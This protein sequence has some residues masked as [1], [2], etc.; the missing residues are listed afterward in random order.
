MSDYVKA[1]KGAENQKRC[2][3]RGTRIPCSA[4]QVLVY[5]MCETGNRAEFK[6]ETMLQPAQVL[7]KK[8]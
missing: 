2:R 6:D 1:H 8:R 3:T 5:E 4:A 7:I